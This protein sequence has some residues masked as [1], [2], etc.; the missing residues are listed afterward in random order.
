MSSLR[1]INHMYAINYLEEGSKIVG[2]NKEDKTQIL[3]KMA[4]C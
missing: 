2:N 3:C 1:W 4:S